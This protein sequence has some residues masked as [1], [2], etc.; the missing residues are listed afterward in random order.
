MRDSNPLKT[1][2]RGVSCAAFLFGLLPGLFNSAAT[3]WLQAA[4]P[5]GNFSMDGEAPARFSVTHGRN[6][7]WR[8]KLPSTGQGTAIVSRGRVFVTSHLPIRAD[9]EYGSNILGMCFD[10]ETGR[11]LWRRTIPG[12]RNTDLSSLFS[13]NTAASPVSD[14]K[15]VCFVNVGGGIKCFDFRGG[16]QWSYDWVPFGR[17]H[18]R[19]HEPILHG[20]SVITVQYPH[21]DLEPIHTTKPGA[22][23]LGRDRRYWTHLQAFDLVTGRR[24]WIAEAGTS[25]HQTSLMGQT[26]DGVPAILTGRGGGHQPPEEPYGL[27]LVNAA[28]GS[29]IWDSPIPGFPSAQNACWDGEYAHAF[30]GQEHLTLDARTGEIVRRT[31][32]VD[33]VSVTRWNGASY[34]RAENV[35][36]KS[37]RRPLTKN[38][39]VLAGRYHYFRSGES[40][41][42]GRVHLDSGR[43]E[44]LQ[45]PVQVI[46]RAGRV[47]DVRWEL[48]QTND[49]K[50]TDGFVASQDRRNAGNGW[51]H[52]SAASGTVIGDRLYLPTMVGMV[53]VLNWNA[54]RLDEKALLSI[55]DLGP[56]GETWTLSSLSFSDGRI[57][58]RTLKE[59]ICIGTDRCV[60]ANPTGGG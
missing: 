21:R 29:T 14:G 56:A 20:G 32:L 55:S 42:I 40:F 17:H 8:A 47:D 45:V 33:G 28:D 11:E 37:A 41:H 4:G 7:I 13:D 6:V 34:V 43:V 18:A 39:N 50:N 22:H 9:T 48:A 2:S 52:V 59:L 54:E 57:Y 44:Y 3:D 36:L 35:R 23:P 27:S 19:L 49:M 5:R 15:R 31:S 1:A 30:A 16:E 38:A 58:A 25:I 60:R 53:Y 26:V 12:V 46:R 51:G 10:A 24:R